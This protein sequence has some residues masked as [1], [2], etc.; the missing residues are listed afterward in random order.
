MTFEEILPGLKAKKSTFAQVGAG[1][2]TTSSSLTPSR[3]TGKAGGDALFPHQR[4]R[5][6]RGLFHVEPDPCDVLATDWVEVH[7]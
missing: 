4:D 2:R 1:R 7:D 6:G 5:R 3:S